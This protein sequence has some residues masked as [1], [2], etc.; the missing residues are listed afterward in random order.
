MRSDD[1]D[2]VGA[3][4]H[5][6]GRLE[7]VAA[8]DMAEPPSGPRSWMPASGGPT[9][10]SPSAAATSPASRTPSSRGW[11]SPASRSSPCGTAAR[12]GGSRSRRPPTR[13]V[14]GE[15]DLALVVGFDKH[16]RGAFAA[17]RPTTASGTGTRETGL[18]V[19][20]QYFAMKARRYLHEHGVSD[21]ALARVAAKRVPQWGGRT[22]CAWRR[23]RADRGGDPG[24]R[25][26]QPAADAVHVL[27]ARAEGAVGARARAR[28]PGG[29]PVRPAGDAS[30]RWPS[31]P[32]GSAR[33]RSS[34]PG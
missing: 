28:R 20:T 21:R 32:G 2:I 10:T 11:A 7:G 3:G 31:G 34:R 16:E 4:M 8:L 19:T 27:P 9:S 22:R 30:R 17:D 18:M 12:P 15:A 24:R 14:A 5:P 13:S 29:R 6:F 26:G 23:T 25:A 1:V 33:S